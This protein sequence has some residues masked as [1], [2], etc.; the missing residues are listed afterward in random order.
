MLLD[1]T[2]PTPTTNWSRLTEVNTLAPVHSPSPVLARM[3]PDGAM[4]AMMYLRSLLQLLGYVSSVNAPLVD[5]T[6]WE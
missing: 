6:W 3:V 5:K 4:H 1:N 2:P